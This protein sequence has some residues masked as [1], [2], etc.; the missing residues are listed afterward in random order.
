MGVWVDASEKVKPELSHEVRI[1]KVIGGRNCIFQAEKAG[2]AEAQS[3]L[4]EFTVTAFGWTTE[5]E[6][7]RRDGSR[8][9][10]RS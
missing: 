6:V 1:S 9:V 10:G 4:K 3:Q 8:E 2:C 7:R 5:F